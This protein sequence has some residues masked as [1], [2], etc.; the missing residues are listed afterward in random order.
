MRCVLAY[1][2]LTLHHLGSL[3]MVHESTILFVIVILVMHVRRAIAARS[4]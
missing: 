3:R 4:P 2:L 1:R